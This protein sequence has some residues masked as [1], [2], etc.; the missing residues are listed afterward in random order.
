MK[1][2]RRPKEMRGGMGA[3]ALDRGQG[4]LMMIREG[5]EEVSAMD[6]WGGGRAANTEDRNKQIQR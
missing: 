3:L 4:G 2:Q 6:I 1:A 5:G